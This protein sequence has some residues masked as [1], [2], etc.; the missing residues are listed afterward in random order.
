M[1]CN[2]YV[3]NDP[4]GGTKYI[5]GTTCSG[6]EAYYYLTI[7][8]QVCMNS[9]LPMIN[10][11]NLQVGD[12]CFPV[13]PTPSTTPY[14]YCYFSARTY[15]DAEFQCPNDGLIYNDLYG[16][17]TFSAAIEGNSSSSHPDLSF[18][19][20]NGTD[21]ETVT[22]LDGQLFTEFI[23]PK[24]NFF[25]TETGCEQVV[26]PDWSLYTPEVTF[27]PLT[28]TP[29]RTPTQ[30]PTPTNTSTQTST[31]TVT[32]T[33]TTTNTST[34]TPTPTNTPTLTST[35]TQTQTQ[36]QT[37]TDTPAPS[38]DVSYNILETPTPTPTPTTTQTPT[39]TST[40]TPT[41][42]TTSTQTP[43][44]TTTS[45]QTPTPTST[46]LYVEWLMS[47]SGVTKDDICS[48]PVNVTYYSYPNAGANANVGEYMFYDSALTQPVAAGWY[49]RGNGITPFGQQVYNTDSSGL[50]IAA[51]LNYTCLPYTPTP[52]VT[53]TP[54][55]TPTTTTTPSVT[56]TNTTT[57]SVTPTT[58]TTPTNTITSTPT[59]TSS[60]TPTPT[61][62]SYNFFASSTG[63]SPSSGACSNIAC[64]INLWSA[65]PILN[66]GTNAF[67]NRELTIP[68][69]GDGLFHAWRINCSGT[70][71]NRRIQSSGFVQAQG[72][73]C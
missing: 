1:S 70:I 18:T 39:E 28:P 3:H 31:P 54:S 23:Y 67:T 38:C 29:T 52:T 63:Y 51:N 45:T 20:T 8:Q 24:V 2:F 21:F 12:S 10:L 53:N 5:S 43:T 33:Q 7:G 37:P 22:I 32:P 64:E 46:P 16:K 65:S 68:Y 62:V 60:P 42:T 40:S 41:P 13:T 47:V 71:F 56:P 50:I 9:D 25:Y 17:L 19:V 73:T 66:N 15:Y 14:E 26:L 61:F 6:T 69:S 30:T 55:V 11:N 57:P 27:C 48:M 36:T 72:V 59:R 35:P 49:R 44:T 34:Q 58:T 4:V